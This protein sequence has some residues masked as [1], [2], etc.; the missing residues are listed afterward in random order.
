MSY[1]NFFCILIK[2]SII[3]L[4]QIRQLI[5]IKLLFLENSKNIFLRGHCG[6]NKY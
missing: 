3:L 4:L 1:D 5:E 2:Y 6:G